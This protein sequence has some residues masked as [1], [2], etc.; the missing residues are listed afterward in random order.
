LCSLFV[1]NENQEKP[2]LCMG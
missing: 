1:K 2:V